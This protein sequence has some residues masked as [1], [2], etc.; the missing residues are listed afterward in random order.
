MQRLLGSLVCALA[1]SACSGGGGEAA[2]GGTEAPPAGLP[3]H[4]PAPAPPPA[5]N[6]MSEAKVE[7]GRHL[8]YDKRLSG[9]GTQAC[10]TC[11]LQAKA[12]TDGLTTAVGSTGQTH[13]RNSQTLTNVVYN[14][15]F[16]WGNPGVTGLE[17][18]N[19]PPI[20]NDDA[21]NGKPVELGIN[22]VN[23]AEVLNRFR[24][25]AA[26]Q[27]RFAAAFPGQS[28]P[29]TLGN[30]VKALAS[31]CRTLLSYRSPF[32]R[33]AQEGE[34][35]N[36]T[37][38]SASAK[39]G[40]V[41]FRSLECGHCHGGFNFS[42]STRS[43][44]NPAVPVFHNTGLYNIT[45]TDGSTNNYPRFNQGVFETSG[46]A[47]DKGKMRAPTLRNIALTAPY[48]HDGSSASLSEVLD[49]YAR[50]GRFVSNP[51]ANFGDGANN[52]NKDA[53][54][55]SFPLSAS[56]KNDLI[57]F[58]N[59]LTDNAFVHDPKLADPFAP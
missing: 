52:T 50:G 8:F 36:S 27:Q 19:L 34:N 2:P 32:D 56:E 59:S 13:P 37:A 15:S 35:P 23:R 48:N 57:E 26:Y 25:D 14:A 28:D 46:N 11:H 17:Q 44:G 20:T 47:A 31:F 49:N 40:L 7:L 5:D 55:H 38:L 21:A 54:A 18:Q 51:V 42:D 4:F 33:F 9:N 41:L 24:N 53:R 3:A 43:A 12:F 39:R 58:L 30:I 10:A 22:D 1:F 29:F 45:H 16:N 6:P